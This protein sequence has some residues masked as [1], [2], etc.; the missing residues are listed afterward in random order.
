MKTNLLTTGL[1]CQNQQKK[2]RTYN[3]FSFFPKLATYV[4]DLTDT[5]LI[6]AVARLRLSSHDLEIERGRHT[7]PKTPVANRI[8]QRCQTTEVDDEI[9]FLMQCNM[10]ELD[11]KALLS[12][13][14]K[15]ITNF[16]TQC[17]TEQFKPIMSSENHAIINALAKYTYVCF[18]KIVVQQT[19]HSRTW[20]GPRASITG[21]ICVVLFRS[22]AVENMCKS[23]EK[24]FSARASCPV[25]RFAAIMGNTDELVIF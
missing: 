25:H 12:E 18:D 14:G 10:F 21:V 24:S 7:R 23:C 20:P 19:P 5:R 9:H 4:S 22:K 6:A 2:L 8:C 3:T 17:N 16:N 13:A 15:Y 11:R 1:S